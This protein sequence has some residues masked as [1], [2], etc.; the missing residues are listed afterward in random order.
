MR[1]DEVSTTATERIK[2]MVL[3][4]GFLGFSNRDWCVAMLLGVDV[5]AYLCLVQC[6]YIDG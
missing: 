2:H 3:E 5:L 4:T 6:S 1:A